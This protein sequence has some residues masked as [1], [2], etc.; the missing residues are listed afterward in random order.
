[1][2]AKP[3][4]KKWWGVIAIFFTWPISLPTLMIFLVWKK[5]NLSSI[6]KIL[7]TLAILVFFGAIIS[8]MG[9]TQTDKESMPQTKNEK[10]RQLKMV[11]DVPSLVGKDIKQI[12][13]V[14][15]PY[16]SSTQPTSKQIA[17][18]V[19]EWAQTWEKDGETLYVTY[20]IKTGKV[21]DFFISTKDSSGVTTDKVYLASVGNLKADQPT[22][23]VSFVEAI[24]DPGKYTGVT[25]T[26][27]DLKAKAE[28]IEKRKKF[29]AKRGTSMFA[30]EQASQLIKLATKFNL[31][32]DVYIDETVSDELKGRYLQGGKEE[33][34]RKGVSS[35]AMTVVISNTTWAYTTDTSKKDFVAM[36]V[37]NLLQM[38][39]KAYPH[40]MVTN[41]LRTVAEGSWSAWS[42]EA[43]VELK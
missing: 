42:G 17:S 43:N 22:Y 28:L 40:V 6:V 4:Y 11:F 31:P 38:Y 21:K 25:I 32:I 12:A 3:W 1:M 18:G 7:L 27:I 2:T 30:A 35:V 36:L 5:F 37:N 15:G 9:G 13:V 34:F 16:V 8:A 19:N 24:N 39:P 20:E 41:G 23:D 10:E 14:L 29:D 33:D 26:P